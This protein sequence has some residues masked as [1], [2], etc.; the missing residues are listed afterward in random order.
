MTR[1]LR[2]K[3]KYEHAFDEYKTE[4]K[5]DVTHLVPVSKEDAARGNLNNKL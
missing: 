5:S 4:F 3:Y 2:R 1:Q